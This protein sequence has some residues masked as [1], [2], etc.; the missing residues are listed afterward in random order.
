MENLHTLLCCSFQ[1][2]KPDKGLMQRAWLEVPVDDCIAPHAMNISR[3][4]GSHPMWGI[5][6]CLLQC[7]IDKYRFV[8]NSVNISRALYLSANGVPNQSLAECCTLMVV[9]S[10][11]NVAYAQTV[12]N[13]LKALRTP[14]TQTASCT[15]CPVFMSEYHT[16]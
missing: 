16:S 11:R 7:L 4:W 12:R 1:G 14:K 3:V 2:S 15:V 10:M 13:L 5:F 8:E 9:L 6:S